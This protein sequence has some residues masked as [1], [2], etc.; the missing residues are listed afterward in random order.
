MSYTNALMLPSSLLVCPHRHTLPN[1]NA[2]ISNQALTLAASFASAHAVVHLFP[3]VY[4]SF[5]FGGQFHPLTSL[6]VAAKYYYYEEMQTVWL[7]VY[8]G[9][10]NL[11]LICT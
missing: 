10:L 5:G 4:C 9:G 6:A 11:R 2:G 1:A 3:S 7:L 8:A